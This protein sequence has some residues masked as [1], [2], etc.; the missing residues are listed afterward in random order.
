VIERVAELLAQSRLPSGTLS[1]RVS[2]EHECSN[3]VWRSEVIAQY[4]GI[5]DACQSVE[6]RDGTDFV[7]FSGKV[8]RTFG[9]SRN[10]A[11]RSIR[12]SP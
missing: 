2:G 3:V 1:A 11:V 9:G 5:G 7:K 10:V 6:R 4:P 12:S 8:V